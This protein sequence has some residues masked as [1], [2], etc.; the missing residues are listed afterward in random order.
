[1][2]MKRL[3]K[4]LF[5]LSAASL[6][7]PWFTYNP[8]IMGYCWGFA[9]AKWYAVPMVMTGV[10]LYIL[11]NGKLAAFLA[12]LSVGMNLW[13]CVIA[14]GRWQEAANIAAGY[15]WSDGLRTAQPG[16]WIAAGLFLALFA[17]FQFEFGKKLGAGC[18]NR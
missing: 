9:F 1:M 18:V 7:L 17:V 10:Y 6:L 5:L 15:R 4:V 14:F 8:R 16:F 2:K 13:I 3:L 11:P 12:E